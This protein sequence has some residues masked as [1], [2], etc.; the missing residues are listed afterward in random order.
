MEDAGIYT[1][2]YRPQFHFLPMRGWIGDPDGMLR[3]QD[4]YHVWW[5]GHAESKRFSALGKSNSISNGGRRWL[6]HL[7]FWFRR[8]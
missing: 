5:W 2:K 1:E 7:L 4:T 3:Y 6:L 8:C